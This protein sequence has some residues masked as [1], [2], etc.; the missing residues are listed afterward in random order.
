MHGI[1][2]KVSYLNLAKMREWLDKEA[3]V[4]LIDQDR[5]E[6]ANRKALPEPTPDQEERKRIYEGFKT[7]SEHLQ[8]G[9]GPST[10]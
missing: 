1:A 10:L 8:A 4:Y 3:S 7:L 9:F 2:S 6:R 5:I